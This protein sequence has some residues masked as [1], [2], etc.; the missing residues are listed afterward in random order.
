MKDINKYDYLSVSVKTDSEDEMVTRYG[1]FGWELIERFD[2]KQFFDIAVI[3]FRRPR[4][5]PNKDRLQYL[6]VGMETAVNNLSKYRQNK[7]A[8]SLAFGLTLGVFGCALLAVGI[9]LIVLSA[10][11][12]IIT[13]G[14]MM[15][16]AI[17][18]FVII[19]TSLKKITTKENS[20]YDE[21]TEATRRELFSIE[22]EATEIVGKHI[23]G[24]N[25]G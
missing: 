10:L 25:N 5:V 9:V 13:G 11:W 19:C 1:A 24:E 4:S 2:D 16:I 20:R 12:S 23:V 21:L 14:L 7:H 8:F 6:Q 18:L 17:V 3:Y 15:A 22:K